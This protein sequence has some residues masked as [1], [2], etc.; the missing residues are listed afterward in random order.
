MEWLDWF[1]WTMR[2]RGQQ[3]AGHQSE[4]YGTASGPVGPDEVERAR[5]YLRSRVDVDVDSFLA[6]RSTVSIFEEPLGK[7]PECL[8]VNDV[9]DFVEKHKLSMPKR[10]HVAACA[11]CRQ[12][13]AT[14]RRAVAS[15]WDPFTRNIK[16]HKADRIWLPK[17]A[18]FFLILTNNAEQ[19]LLG[20]LDPASILVTGAIEAA[21]CRLDRLD[22]KQ[23]NATEAVALRFDKYSLKMPISKT[24]N[25]PVADWLEVSGNA[26]GTPVHKQALVCVHVA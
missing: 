1:P 22:A 26:A 15:D 9:A 25:T 21:G 11:D 12:S 18:D 4:R 7:T 17:G 3:E 10:L 23:F 24:S 8:S 19:E 20:Q 5:E 13:V 16:I 6:H 14:Y 2:R